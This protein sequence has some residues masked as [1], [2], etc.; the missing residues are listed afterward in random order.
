MYPYSLSVIQVSGSLKMPEWIQKYV[1]YTLKTSL[2][3]CT[4]F[5]LGGR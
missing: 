2:S 5:R 3:L 4:H 1:I